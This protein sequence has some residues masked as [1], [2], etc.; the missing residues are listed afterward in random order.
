MSRSEGNRS[1]QLYPLHSVGPRVL[2]CGFS[3]KAVQHPSWKAQFA[4]FQHELERRIAAKKQ[5]AR[6]QKGY[7]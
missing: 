3:L 2:R 5:E 4:G 1:K 6:E 7:Y